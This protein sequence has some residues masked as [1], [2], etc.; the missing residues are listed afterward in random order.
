MSNNK[1]FKALS[2]STRIKMLQILTKGEKHLSGLARELGIAVPVASRHIKIL[3]NAGLINKK[4]IGNVYLLTAKIKGLEEILEQFTEE[5]Q[6]KIN[7]RDSLLDALKQLPGVESKTVDG[8][9]YITSVDGDNGFYVYEVDGELPKVSVDKYKP[10]KNVTVN[11]KKI[12]SVNKKKIEVKL[13]N[14]KID[15]S[16][17]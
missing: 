7:N 16:K 11:L 14:K 3:E 10:K 13:N 4:I 6:V 15:K 9:Q 1:L 8:K 2:S 17:E 12:I 5:A